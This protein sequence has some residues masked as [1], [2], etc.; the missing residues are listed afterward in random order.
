MSFLDLNENTD[1]ELEVEQHTKGTANVHIRNLQTQTKCTATVMRDGKMIKPYVRKP[2]PDDQTPRWLVDFEYIHE[3]ENQIE[4][5]PEQKTTLIHIYTK[6]GRFAYHIELQGN[7]RINLCVTDGDIM[8]NG[9]VFSTYASFRLDNGKSEENDL[10]TT[11]RTTAHSITTPSTMERNLTL[12]SFWKGEYEFS[13]RITSTAAPDVA[14]RLSNFETL[15]DI[16]TYRAVMCDIPTQ[17]H[18][19]TIP[20]S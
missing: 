4:G 2:Q 16:G 14:T 10:Q 19:R 7:E 18:H 12:R 17:S 15:T 1:W 8:T 13:F 6:P 11:V 3:I 20:V 9:D 5:Q